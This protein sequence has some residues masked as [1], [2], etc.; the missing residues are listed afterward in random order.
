M[1]SA[2]TMFLNILTHVAF[3]SKAKQV[4][5]PIPMDIIIEMNNFG[6]I[7]MCALVTEFSPVRES[8]AV[9]VGKDR[10]TRF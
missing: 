1:K 7:F 3:L 6:T 4:Q 8:T 9:I 2:V 5:M 10:H